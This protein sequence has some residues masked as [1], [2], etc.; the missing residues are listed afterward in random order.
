[1]RY[2]EGLLEEILRRTDIVRLVGARV[3]LARRGRVFWGLCPFHKEKSPS[4]K[5][6]NERRNYKCFGCGEGGSA[7]KWLMEI[8]GLSFREAVER[9]AGETGVALPQWT[10]D[11]EAREQKKKSLYEIVETACVF[12]E[13][14]LQGRGGARARDYLAS[15]GLDEAAICRFRLGFAPNSHAALIDELAAKAIPPEDAA[16]AGLVRAAEDGRPARDF[17]YNRLMFPI[18]DFRGRVIAFG[19]RALEADAKPKYINTGETSLFSKGELLYNFATARAAALKSGTVIVAEGYMDV[20]ALVRAG[21]EAA[22]APLGTA[23]TEDQLSLLWRTA[24][25]PILCFDGD[26]AGTRAARRAARLALPLLAPGH[27]L[28]FAFLPAGEDPDSF[29]RSQGAPAMKRVLDAAEPLAQMLWRMETDGHEFTTPERRAGL[30]RALGEI[31]GEMCDSK[32]AGYYRRDFDNRVFD[33]FKRWPSKARTRFRGSR[34]RDEGRGA[35]VESVS[36]AV[37]NSLLARSSGVQPLKEME[38]FSLLLEAP[39]IVQRQGELLAALPLS[40]RSLDRLRDELLNLAASGFRLETGRLEDHLVRA[41]MSE[42]VERL[43]ARRARGGSSADATRDGSLEE[44]EARWLAAALQLREIAEIGPERR[45]AMER[46]K[47]EANEETWS[48]AHR[49]LV[50]RGLPND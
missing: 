36:P 15:R 21:F 3:K 23:L 1:M 38:L 39:E 4:F 47:S 30:E 44:T 12:F 40:D 35:P 28:R 8:E 13:R 18:A 9:L 46:F 42:L 29:T 16:A 22:V 27:S 41:G 26:D 24:P 14:Q 31:V 2:G 6:D 34:S 7:F 25:E 49:L 19:A 5:V 17:F 45:Q 10:P 33:L 32:V 43:N 50:S 48:G 37:R 11:D 20:I